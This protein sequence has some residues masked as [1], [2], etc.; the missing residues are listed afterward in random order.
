MTIKDGKD[1]IPQVKDLIIEYTN[2]L[3]RDLSFQRIDEE[4]AIGLYR[5]NGFKE[6]EPYYD[7][8]MDDVIYM[9][10]KL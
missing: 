8:P 6:C 2:R 10:K 4:L 5:K 1:Y 3:N 9:I 7:N